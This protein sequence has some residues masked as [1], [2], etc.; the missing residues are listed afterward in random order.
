MSRRAETPGLAVGDKFQGVW[1]KLPQPRCGIAGVKCVLSS[2]DVCAK[3][4][5]QDRGQCWRVRSLPFLS[6]RRHPDPSLRELA[7]GIPPTCGAR[8]VRH[9]IVCVRPSRRRRPSLIRL[10]PGSA[11]RLREEREPSR[12]TGHFRLAN[13]AGE[14]GDCVAPML[15]CRSTHVAIKTLQDSWG[16]EGLSI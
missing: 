12:S 9:G 16:C 13:V 14:R 5:L 15:P 1:G 11:V 10:A 3:A 6:K 4:S 2:C 7:G 8:R